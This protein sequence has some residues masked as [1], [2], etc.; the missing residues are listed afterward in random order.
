MPIATRPARWRRKG[1]TLTSGPTVQ[2]GRERGRES[3]DR[4][5]LPRS[6]RGKGRARRLSAA[7]RAA[8]LGR[9]RVACEGRGVGPPT[10]QGQG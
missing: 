3:A 7:E 4:Q 6:E 8:P 10:A 1:E 9:A 2:R 5:A